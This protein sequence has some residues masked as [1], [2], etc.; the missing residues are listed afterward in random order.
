MGQQW[1]KIKNQQ[2]QML[3]SLDLQ[4][5]SQQPFNFAQSK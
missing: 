1:S 4:E 3:K 2:D 5:V